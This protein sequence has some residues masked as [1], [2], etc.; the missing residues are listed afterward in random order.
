MAPLA[1]IIWLMPMCLPHRQRLGSLC[2]MAAAAC[3]PPLTCLHACHIHYRDPHLTA[4]VFCDALHRIVLVVESAVGASANGFF[5]R[6]VAVPA[7]P[8][9]QR[10]AHAQ[11][12]GPHCQHACRM[13]KHAPVGS[14]AAVAGRS[15]G[16]RLAAWP[17]DIGRRITLASVG[18]MH[19]GTRTAPC[20]VRLDCTLLSED[21]RMA[22][23]Y[24]RFECRMS[25]GSVRYILLYA[26]LAI[27][28]EALPTTWNRWASTAATLGVFTAVGVNCL[29]SPKRNLRQ[30]SDNLRQCER[31][32]EQSWPHRPPAIR[33][34]LGGQVTSI[35]CPQSL[36]THPL[37][38][39]ITC[40]ELLNFKTQSYILRRVLCVE[41]RFFEVH[42]DMLFE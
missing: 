10:S 31:T 38:L 19:T 14:G 39:S 13:H 27:D 16:A 42:S 22:H 41:P 28:S 33:T 12:R 37:Y 32:C 6:A 36:E 9:A 15:V 40:K 11:A 4:L 30:C 2:L 34:R 23:L 29:K 3:N 17:L 25:G 21:R 26:C 7:V 1:R 20:T 35:P 5:G 18:T 8:A 24:D